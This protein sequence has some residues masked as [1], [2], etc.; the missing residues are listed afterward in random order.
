MGVGLI[1][2]SL[3][4]SGGAYALA[5]G[6]SKK[7]KKI[8]ACVHHKGRGLYIARHRRCVR[9]DK[10]LRWNVRGP[11]GPRGPRGLRGR[12]GPQ[13]SQGTQ[14][15]QGLQ[16]PPGP[17]GP[18]DAYF[19]ASSSGNSTL[20]LPAGKYVMTARAFLTLAVPG[21]DTCTLTAG[22]DT[23]SVA[24]T[25]PATVTMVVAHEFTSAGT[26]SVACTSLLGRT[27]RIVAIKVGTLTVQ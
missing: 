10:K 3:A 25:A 11:R 14:G 5:S 9:R 12:Q 15:A 17:T 7:P 24:G 20:S 18:S 19:T 26:A 23:D 27:I 16:G 1:V 8:V 2:L 21:T 22:S 6:S 13:G 4:V